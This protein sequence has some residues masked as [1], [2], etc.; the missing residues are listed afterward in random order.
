MKRDRKTLHANLGNPK[1]FQAE[2]NDEAGETETNP[3]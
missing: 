2:Q 3:Y 1:A